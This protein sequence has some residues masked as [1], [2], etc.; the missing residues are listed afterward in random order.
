MEEVLCE[1]VMCVYM[2]VCGEGQEWVCSTHS[3]QKHRGA[4]L[5]S[6]PGLMD[7]RPTSPW[8]L[9]PSG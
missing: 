6:V 3:T 1:C 2:C 5:I 4:A 8:S 9:G 7:N